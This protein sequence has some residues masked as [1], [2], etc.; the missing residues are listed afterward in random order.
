M[1]SQK[2]AAIIQVLPF[3]YD[4]NEVQ[5]E[6][7]GAGGADSRCSVSGVTQAEKAAQALTHSTMTC[8]SRRLSRK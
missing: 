7:L 2:V 5:L 1:C 4:E 8:P 3:G 6:R